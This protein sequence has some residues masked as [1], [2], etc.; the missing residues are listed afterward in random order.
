VSE[1]KLP[2]GTII[3]A[4]VR[5]EEVFMSLTDTVVE[6]NDHFI[7]FVTDKRYVPAVEKLFQVGLHFF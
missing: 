1:V 2:P 6:A 7:I 5:K 4:L 3:G